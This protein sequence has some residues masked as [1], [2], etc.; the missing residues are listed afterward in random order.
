MGGLKSCEK[1]RINL[2]TC[3]GNEIKKS[4]SPFLPFND[5]VAMTLQH[6]KDK[7]SYMEQVIEAKKMNLEITDSNGE[8]LSQALLLK[9][10][11]EAEIEYKPNKV[12]IVH[13]K[14]AFLV[15]II[16]N[17]LGERTVSVVLED[18]TGFVSGKKNRKT[19]E[20]KKSEPPKVEDQTSRR[21]S[22]CLLL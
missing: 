7:E 2:T 14:N 12:I 20:Y 17:Y 6:F 18:T 22:G 19:V 3:E 21:C 4:E 11:K 5:N 10:L 9:V 1:H 15:G 16:L 8:I 13:G